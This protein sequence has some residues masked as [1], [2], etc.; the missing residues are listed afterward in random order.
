MDV[1]S[2]STPDAEFYLGVERFQRERRTLI[3]GSWQLVAHREQLAGPGDYVATELG[4]EP[5]VL[6]RNAGGLAG[7]FNV[8]RH[9]AGPVATGCGRAR[10]LVCRYHGWSYG[11]DG[12]LERAP[13]MQGVR[14]FDPAAVRL[15]PLAV[16]EWGPLVFA[17]A[18]AGA[19]PFEEVFA[20]VR[21]RCA[22]QHLDG[23]RFV[24][25][26]TFH[27]RANWKVYVDNYLEGYHIP[28][29]HPGLNREIDYRS[30]D[31]EIGSNYAAQVGRVNAAAGTGAGRRFIARTPDEEAIY[32]WVF[33]NLML[34]IYQG[35][36][37]TN[38]VS[39]RGVADTEVRFDWF[40]L[41]R[42]AD[43]AGEERFRDLVAFA[44]E[45]Q[46][47]DAGICEAVARNIASRAYLPGRY[48]ALREA[49]VHR[50]HALMRE[51]GR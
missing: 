8:C 21:A 6:V 24:M 22:R 45:I 32:V 48:S 11:L 1:A 34:N 29:V 41:E 9:R 28:A 25:T 19:R 46:A 42:P 12:V 35:I 17:N 7:F 47:E 20:D 27:V 43:A 15:A 30:Y 49:G 16:A 50:F 36:L 13:E 51:R 3:P 37:Q 44:G 18:D 39:P 14:G 31:T 26:E 5:V 40:A 2:A 38:V 10:R 33:P 23:M 4:S